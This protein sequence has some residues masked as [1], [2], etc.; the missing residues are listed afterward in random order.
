MSNLVLN[1]GIFSTVGDWFKNLWI[2]LWLM[3]DNVIYLFIDWMY[4]VFILV[5]EIDIFGGGDQIKEITERLYL[6]VGI[7]MLFIFAY[8]LVLLIINPEGN[9][10]GAMGKVV[11]NALISIIFV[12]L[13]PLI[14]S[15]LTTIQNHVI[16]SNVIGHV[17]FGSS[18][19]DLNSNKQYGLDASFTIFSAFYHPEGDTH[20]SCCYKKNG[21][22][23]MCSTYCAAYDDAMQ[24]ESISNFIWNDELKKGVLNG[25]MEYN[26]IISSIAGGF[27][28]WMFISFALDIGIRVGKLAFYE[29]I[30]PIPVMM[31]I[32][33]NDKMYPKWF[34]GITKTYFSLFIRLAV[35]FFCMYAITLV[36]DVLD[37]MWA[38]RG[39]NVIILGLANILVI[40]GILKF[41]Q[42]APKLIGDLFGSGGG[43]DFSIGKKYKEAGKPLGRVRDTAK[44]GIYGA[45]TAEKG[46]GNRFKGF[47]AGAGRGARY[48]YDE[49]TRRLDDA[50]NAAQEGS[51]FG[52]RMQDRLRN[53]IGMKSRADQT[54]ADRNRQLG[55]LDDQINAYN[56]RL[57]NVARQR[58]DMH[59]DEREANNNEVMQYRSNITD[60]IA[61]EAKKTS[62]QFRY[63]NSLSDSASY[64][65]ENGNKVNISNKSYSDLESIYNNAQANGVSS[66]E[67]D[68]IKKHMDTRFYT[69]ANGQKMELKGDYQSLLAAQREA[70]LGIST[71]P[72]NGSEYTVAELEQLKQRAVANGANQDFIDKLAGAINATKAINEISFVDKNGSRHEISGNLS[73]LE[74][75]FESAKANG[76]SS[77]ILSKINAAKDKAKKNIEKQILSSIMDGSADSKGVGSAAIESVN[78]NINAINEM[79]NEGR[80]AQD[81]SGNATVTVEVQTAD[82]VM[83]GLKDAVEYQ[84]GQIADETRGLNRQ[85]QEIERQK[86]EIERQKQ[87]IERQKN[88]ETYKS[89]RADAD[90]VNRNKKNKNNN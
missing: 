82:D 44:A 16:E 69:D 81:A 28:L 45:T 41:A 88:S 26:Y 49:G 60:A 63:T 64:M 87:E 12:T 22:S 36:P 40:L 74:M 55:E 86:Q 4:R 42:E 65:D 9:Q 43:L 20:Y 72:A 52:G 56:E 7:A 33:P 76:E 14:F 85:K 79:I 34:D 77:E 67:L 11:K 13:L 66:A 15:W 80:V 32:L 6:I 58:N 75:M 62:S 83:K 53:M 78:R 38:D 54:D 10:L 27:A 21:T 1:A 18:S 24:N 23:S 70:T 47:F 73:E 90:A 5:A 8:N 71:P 30:A 37:G 57:D 48:G 84:K 50:R 2:S 29:V 61:K 59:I 39:D 89:Q 31:R 25:D 35:I 17:I 46:A 51:T 68:K 19:K 3:I